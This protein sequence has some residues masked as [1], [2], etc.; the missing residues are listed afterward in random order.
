MPMNELQRRIGTVAALPARFWTWARLAV[1]LHD[2]G[3]VADGFQV[4]VGNS[5]QPAKPWGERHE[6]YSL[7]FVARV[8][9]NL[10]PEDRLWVATGVATHHRPFT[11]NGEG[12]LPLFTC[13]D[14]DQAEFAD[15]FGLCR[16]PA[17]RGQRAAWAEQWTGRGGI[18]TL[19]E[20]A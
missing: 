10:E 6:V 19:R 9:T 4:M 7:G 15:R 14:L 2:A 17:A 18:S 11:G 1:L 3:K 13:Y 8:L 20:A 12:R 5:E 16:R